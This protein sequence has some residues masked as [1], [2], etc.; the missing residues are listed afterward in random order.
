MYCYGSLFRCRNFDNVCNSRQ[1]RCLALARRQPL[2]RSHPSDHTARKVADATPHLGEG[3]A[4]TRHPTFRQPRLADAQK[5]GSLLRREQALDSGID[6]ADAIC[7]VR[8]IGGARVGI[9]PRGAPRASVLGTR[10]CR[11]TCHDGFSMSS[12]SIGTTAWEA[13]I[14]AMRTIRAPA[15]ENDAIGGAVCTVDSD[16][17]ARNDS[18]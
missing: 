3:R 16:G 1:R 15:P 14:R 18:R 6:G 8:C 10:Q 5:I 4:V 2:V 9:V 13:K 12:P 7:R 17:S 11:P